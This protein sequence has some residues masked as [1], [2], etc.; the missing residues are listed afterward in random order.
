MALETDSGDDNR[1][2]FRGDSSNVNRRGWSGDVESLQIE[3][4]DEGH[5]EFVREE[6]GKK[7]HKQQEEGF[8]EVTNVGLTNVS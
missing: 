7:R 4:Y 6:S 1:R 8:I 2:G 3:E 5:W